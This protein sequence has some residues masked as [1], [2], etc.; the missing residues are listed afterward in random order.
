[1]QKIKNFFNKKNIY[2]ILSL[3]FLLC[4][5]GIIAFI[6]GNSSKDSTQSSNDSDKIVE[7]V[8]E[9]CE[10]IGIQTDTSTVSHCVR[11]SAHFFEFM[12]LGACLSLSAIF[13]FGKKAWIFAIVST[14]ISFAVA[15][16]DEF[17]FQA[18]SAGRSPEFRDVLLDTSGALTAVIIVSLIYLLIIKIAE[19]KKKEVEKS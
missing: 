19:R 2:R 6:F 9:V 16:T 4:A 1:M 3:F 7:K 15:M 18:N 14:V 5:A 11:K 13:A 10:E 8:E 12:L 17:L